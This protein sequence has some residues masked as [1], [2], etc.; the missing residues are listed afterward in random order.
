VTSRYEPLAALARRERELIDA[1]RWDELH[2][3]GAEWQA[4]AES[5]PDPSPADREVLE[6][7]AATV[8]ST[9]AAVE[10][11]LADTIRGMG[12]VQQGRLAVDS[13]GADTR[14]AA[15]DARG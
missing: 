14:R 3:L 12:H 10:A 7:I 6:E 8:W 15:L 13:Y 5:M 11:A 4:H 2:E 1:N 9:V